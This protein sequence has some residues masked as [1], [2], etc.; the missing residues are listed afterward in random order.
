MGVM[1]FLGSVCYVMVV[2]VL[3]KIL[4]YKSVVCFFIDYFL[5]MKLKYIFIIFV[6]VFGVVVVGV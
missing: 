3:R 2:M 1:W 4:W 5:F 6:F